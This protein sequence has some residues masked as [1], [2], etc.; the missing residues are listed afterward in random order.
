MPTN[1]WASDEKV[2]EVPLAGICLGGSHQ[3]LQIHACT[4][5]QASYCPSTSLSLFYGPL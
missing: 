3:Q 5:S 4:H 2:Q 1:I